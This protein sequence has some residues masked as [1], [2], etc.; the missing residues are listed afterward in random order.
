M[1]RSRSRAALVPAF[2]LLLGVSG[3]QSIARADDAT[4]SAKFRADMTTWFKDAADKLDQL[5]GAVPERKYSWRPNQDVRS[6]GEV[7]L[8]V[9]SANYGVPAMM[10][11]PA[12]EGFKFET[13]EKSLSTKAEIQKALHESFDHLA[14]AFANTADADLDKEVDF[15]GTRMTERSVYLEML[16][17]AHEHLGQSIAYARTNGIV[18][19]WTAREQAEAKA[20][21]AKARTEKK[22]EKLAEDQAKSGKN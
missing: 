15:F 5:A 11:T 14:T 4:E 12:P 6:I 19:P 17:H 1:L 16:C 13:Y 9:A 8:H 20:A 7:Y 22:S 21:A 18:P 10:G 3:F 2:V